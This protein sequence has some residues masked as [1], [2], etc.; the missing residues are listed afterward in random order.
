M[1]FQIAGSM[2]FQDAAKAAGLQMLEPI[3]SVVVYVPAEFLSP[4]IGDLNKR[5]ATI[6]ELN[7]SKEPNEVHAS[8]PLAELFGYTTVLRSLSQGR[9]SCEMEPFEYQPVPGN[10]KIDQK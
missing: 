4:I 2:A 5:R 7:T 3:M 10:I 6:G 9:A 8:T 1:A